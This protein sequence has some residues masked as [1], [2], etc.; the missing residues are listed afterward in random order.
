M[1][2]VCTCVSMKYFND[3]HRVAKGLLLCSCNR[4][5][6]CYCMYL[7]YIYRIIHTQ[8]KYVAID[9]HVNAVYFAI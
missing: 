9:A 7:F 5:V 8:T 2:M 4:D 6:V 1:P 3:E